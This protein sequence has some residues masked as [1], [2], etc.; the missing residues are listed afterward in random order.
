MNCIEPKSNSY[1]NKSLL[2]TTILAVGAILSLAVGVYFYLEQ[3]RVLL[4]TVVSQLE[5][6]EKLKTEQILNWRNER[7]EDGLALTT[8]PTFVD[9]VERWSSDTANHQLLEE[10]IRA[11]LEPIRLSYKYADILLLGAGKQ[12]HLSLVGSP[13]VAAEEVTKTMDIAIHSHRP[14]LSDLYR[15][16][17][18]DSIAMDVVA[19]VFSRSS[20]PELF[21]FILLRIDPS[22]VLY[23]I[24]Q[25][26]PTPTRTGETLLAR[27]DGDS[28]LYLNAL[29]RQS[30]AALKLRI[31]LTRTDIPAVQ[32]VIGRKGV[33][34]GND[35]SGEVVLAVAHNIP[36]TTWYLL[37]KIDNDEVLEQWRSSGVL[38]A[39]VAILLAIGLM[40]TAFFVWAQS[41]NYQDLQHAEYKFADV[42]RE[43]ERLLLFNE[44][45][46][47]AIPT[48]V[49][50][51]DREGLYLGCNNAFSET[52][53]VTSSEIKG[54]TVYDL[55]SS[56]QARVHHQKD[57]EL[58]ANPARQTYEFNI[59][60]K[61]GLMHPVIF[62]RDVFRDEDSN[63]VGIIGA[64]VDITERKY[65]EIEQQKLLSELQRSHAVLEDQQRALRS[66]EARFR[67][68]IEENAYGMVV[69][70]K[71]GAVLL[72]NPAAENIF[73]KR[74]EEL[75]G[76]T[77]GCSLSIGGSSEFNILHSDGAK[78]IV[79]IDLVAFE[80]DE[81]PAYLATLRDIT[82]KKLLE[83]QLHEAKDKAL[84]AVAAKSMFLANMSHEIR[85]PM[86][87]V[88]GM[89]ELLGDSE[90]SSEQR[91]LLQDI[92]SSGDLLLHLI[93]DVLD[94]SKIEAGKIELNLQPFDLI[95]LMN[96]LKGM[97]S[98][99]ILEKNLQVT[100]TV[101]PEVPHWIIGDSF[102]LQQVLINLL[103]NAVKF[104]PK[105][106]NITLQVTLQSVQDDDI[107][108]SF[109][110]SDTGIGISKQKQSEIF[111][112]FAQA[113]SST[114][115]QFGGT[116]LG[117]SIA[118]Q[119]VGLM[120][121]KLSL[122]SEEGIGSV[123]SFDALFCRTS[124]RISPKKL[125]K[126]V[127]E[128][129][130][131]LTP[132]Q[133]LVAED[134][135]INQRLVK[136]IL[137]KAGHIV[138]L[139]NDGVEA[140]NLY[141]QG[142]YDIILMDIQMPH[143]DGVEAMVEIHQF[144]VAENRSKTPIVALTANALPGDREKYLNMGMDEYLTKPI[145]RDELYRVILNCSKLAQ[146]RVL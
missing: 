64:F 90:L 78:Q 32:A 54:K 132:Q 5:G 84:A 10:Q 94:I 52:L 65:L 35:Y 138:T 73:R 31:P 7:V 39:A 74:E 75:I 49:F 112:P 92:K 82:K 122:Q 107:R 93:N 140:V 43:R 134:N 80:W 14:I 141:R 87:G 61:D 6:I 55:C 83:A 111:E 101:A 120:G 137:S 25:N 106:G 59:Q 128:T 130:I 28:V 121:G 143:K 125:D 129:G 103:G 36:D 133:I 38:I 66:S 98:S 146:S 23:P 88:L 96:T 42:Q 118:R 26:W 81:R 124:E 2:L 11:E 24:I 113:D 33:I 70:D 46:L 142:K 12:I 67:K 127:S 13:A 97:I 44:A 41:K 37:S 48:P 15:T 30:D 20:K 77:L 72:A 19:P 135:R 63:V 110:V 34:A 95:S 100:F 56:E 29:R 71:N 18:G 136:Q 139:A 53:G 114:T 47:S 85:T 68:I 27:Q 115:R 22:V 21:G 109:S 117:L 58:M 17:P 145:N 79:Q 62:A 69:L 76:S 8:R 99:P 119:L 86:N 51:K 126:V 3:K 60:Y 102:R 131:S 57:L 123:F 144:E 91:Q 89:A 16:Q 1:V 104:T 105:Y 116:G 108:I 50:Y 4:H 45:L 9:L 40:G